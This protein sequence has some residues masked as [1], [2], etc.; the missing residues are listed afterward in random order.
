MKLF[1]SIHFLQTIIL[2]VECWLKDPRKWKKKNKTEK[3][4][5]VLRM[6]LLYG[7]KKQVSLLVSASPHFF[8]GSEGLWLNKQLLAQNSGGQ[9]WPS[10][11]DVAIENHF[12][13]NGTKTTTVPS[14]TVTY[15]SRIESIH[16]D[17]SIGSTRSPVLPTFLKQ[18]LITYYILSIL[19]FFSPWLLNLPVAS[20]TPTTATFFC[21]KALF[22][23]I[24]RFEFPLM[25]GI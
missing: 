14:L 10:T 19:W 2:L 12:Q 21:P 1:F 7:K 18:P 5:L 3:N 17:T 23:S 9:T 25:I 6:M 8:V 22:T 20:S 16:T 11:L 4:S 13:V 15:H 24:T